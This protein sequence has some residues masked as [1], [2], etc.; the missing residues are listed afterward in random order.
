[1]E[2]A[3]GFLLIGGV[4]T[5]IDFPGSGVTSTT[6][7]GINDGG[8]V[9][10]VYRMNSPGTGFLFSGGVYQVAIVE[11]EFDRRATQVARRLFSPRIRT[12]LAL[13]KGVAV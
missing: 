9:V 11:A 12:H 10:G 5:A 7:S 2:G 13:S 3:H 6:P 1:L 4:F 8:D